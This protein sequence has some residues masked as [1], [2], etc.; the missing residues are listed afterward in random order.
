MAAEL[1]VR[2]IQEAVRKRYADVAQSAAGQFGYPTGRA[3]AMQLGYE[4]VLLGEM[5]DAVL[6]SFCGVGNPFALGAIHPGE[7]V[8]D[9]GCGAGFDVIVASRLV[10]QTGR[11]YGIDLTPEMVARAQHN[12]QYAGVHHARVVQACAEALPYTT[13]IFDVVLSNGVLNLS[14]LKRQS[15]RE[16]A[17]VL[18]P[19]GRLQWADIVLQETLPAEV[20]DNLDAWAG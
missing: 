7:M 5:P 2:A 8:L 20:A 13:G 17:R 19:G 10:G 16:M 18:K 14:P 6:A 15:F 4:P 1:D 3:G 11:V 12:L 9:V